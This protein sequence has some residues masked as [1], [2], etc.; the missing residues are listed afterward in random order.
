[1]KAGHSSIKPAPV[2]AFRELLTRVR[3]ARARRAFF[4]GFL[5]PVKNLLSLADFIKKSVFPAQALRELIQF[6]KMRHNPVQGCLC[7][8]GNVPCLNAGPVAL[9]YKAAQAMAM[10]F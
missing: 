1:M 10:N 7:F 9:F 8:A 5:P 4:E 6:F 2:A 3:N